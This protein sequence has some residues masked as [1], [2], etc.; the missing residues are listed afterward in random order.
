MS[1]LLYETD[2]YIELVQYL[3]HDPD[4]FS[5]WEVDEAGN[6]KYSDA[7]HA[8]E[9]YAFY[10]VRCVYRIDKTTGVI[11]YISYWDE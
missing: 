2:K 3:H 5:S 10:E 11:T 6:T 8:A 9:H 7:V 4:E 1:K